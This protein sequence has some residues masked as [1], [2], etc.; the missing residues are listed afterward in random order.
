MLQ[1]AA[2]YATSAAGYA[3]FCQIIIPLCGPSCK[4]W[5]ARLSANQKFQDGPSVA[6]TPQYLSNH[7]LDLTQILNLS[8]EDKTKVYNG[9]K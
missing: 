1:C 9:I 2:G 8:K 3:L 4:L 6:K 5:L 7:W